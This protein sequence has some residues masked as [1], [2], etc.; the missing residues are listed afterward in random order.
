MNKALVTAAAALSGLF[1]CL[2]A[3]AGFVGFAG[4]DAPA[5]WTTT[6]TGSV[7]GGNN[8]NVN[9]TGAPSS[10][11]ITGGDDPSDTSDSP[12]NG[13]TTTAGGP[14][15][16][17]PGNCEI[18]FTISGQPA[19]FLFNWTYSTNDITP[20]YDQ[21]G[22]IVNGAMTELIANAG[23]L[24]QSGSFAVI[25]ASRFGWYINCTDCEGGTASA[26]ISNLRVP[27][28]ATLAL[29]GFGLGMLQLRRRAGA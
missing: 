25:G 20:Q 24:V 23:P 15:A 12:G 9:T 22:V 6:T 7:F 16:G 27:E 10:I 26:T 2:P 13:C 17:V 5:N 11:A 19:N 8:G 3:T 21:F 4:P 29:L 28:P 14:V 1:V 18:S